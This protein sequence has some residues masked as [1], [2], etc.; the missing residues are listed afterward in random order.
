MMTDEFATAVRQ[1]QDDGW[2]LIDGLV[3]EVD[4]D[5]A[6]DDVALLFGTDTF[7]DYNKAKGS[8]EFVAPDGKAFREQQFDGMRGFPFGG[9]GALNDLFVHPRMLEFV[10]VAMQSHDL[11]IYQ[12]AVW[13]KN[14]GEV[15]SYGSSRTYLPAP[16]SLAAG[17]AGPGSARLRPS[18]TESRSSKLRRVATTPKCVHRG[19]RRAASPTSGEKRDRYVSVERA[20]S[21]MARRRLDYQLVLVSHDRVLSCRAGQLAESNPQPSPLS[22]FGDTRASLDQRTAIGTAITEFLK[23]RPAHPHG[24]PTPRSP[25]RPNDHQP[26]IGREPRPP[27]IRL[28]RNRI[29]NR[30]PRSR[31]ANRTR[32]SGTSSADTRGVLR[33]PVPPDRSHRNRSDTS[34]TPSGI[35]PSEHR[36]QS[37][38]GHAAGTR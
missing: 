16:V 26:W 34:P 23:T 28:T 5:A 1:W 11:R 20:P 9:S 6:A 33:V 10:R 36:I 14:A 38:L 27:L 8:G 13:K 7:A 19:A 37:P 30:M 32:H 22:A 21:V 18:I 25:Q 4:I 3:P 35:N 17:R 2:A 12:A 24:R 15:L 29:M 31:H